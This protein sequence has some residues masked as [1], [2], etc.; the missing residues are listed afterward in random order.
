M[1]ARYPVPTISSVRLNPV[2]TPVTMF[3]ICARIV[4][5]AGLRVSRSALTRASPP[6]TTTRVPLRMWCASSPLGPLT[7][8]RLASTA[9][10][11][12]DGIVTGRLPTLDM[13]LPL[14]DLEDDLAAEA[15]VAR[16]TVGHQSTRGGND[17]GAHAAHH[18]RDGGLADV[19]ATARR[20]HPANAG[21]DG[22][23]VRGVAQVDPQGVAPF[24]LDHLE[25][26]DVALLHEH[27]R[28][29]GLE[30]RNGDVHLALL[31]ADRVAHAGQEVRYGITDCHVASWAQGR[32]RPRS[33][34]SPGCLP[35]RFHDARDLP[36]QRQLAEADAAQAEVTQVAARTPAAMAA[37][38]GANLELRCSLP[39][40]D[41]RL[42][43]HDSSCQRSRKGIRMSLSNSRPSSSFR[44][45]VTMVTSIP[46][47]FC[48][49]S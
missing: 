37:G 2:V 29:L 17:G 35:A 42:L 4:P 22:G 8:T 41:D 3:E 33:L 11:T 31:G 15:R 46:R 43:G 9:T 13:A 26:V 34:A 1:L 19:H 32:F 28:D 7:L 10:V 23:V 20:A 25:I 12:P 30:T 36:R 40:L 14:P 24:A 38:V 5:N 44:A 49:L 27:L 45:V 48:T 18:L 21:D 47:I 39:L 6:S 16:L